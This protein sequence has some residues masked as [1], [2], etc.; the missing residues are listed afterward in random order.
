MSEKEDQQNKLAEFVNK[1]YCS[2]EMV[3]AIQK[4]FDG[5]LKQDISLD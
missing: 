1:R 4:L 5:H 3:Q 2:Q